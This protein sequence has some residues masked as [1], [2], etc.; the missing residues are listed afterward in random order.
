MAYIKIKWL[1]FSHRMIKI[2]QAT[3]TIWQQQTPLS[4]QVGNPHV[5]AFTLLHPE[6]P[7]LFTTL[8]HT[9]RPKLYTI[10]AFL[11]AVG[12][13]ISSLPGQDTRKS[14]GD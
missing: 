11:S 13:I 14:E 1:V 4:Q 8:L 2:I 10:L 6:R 7:K 5:L 12:V 3:Y 9:E